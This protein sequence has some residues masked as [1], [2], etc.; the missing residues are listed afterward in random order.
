MLLDEAGGDEFTETESDW[1]TNFN[2]PLNGE[3]TVNNA[4]IEAHNLGANDEELSASRNQ[5]NQNILL[6]FSTFKTWRQNHTIKSA[7][8]MCQISSNFIL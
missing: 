2:S 6:I 1:P 3:D 5:L 8:D 4:T 7:V